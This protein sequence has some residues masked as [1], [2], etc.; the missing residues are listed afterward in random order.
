MKSLTEKQILQYAIKGLTADIDE[1]EKTVN[2]GK[3]YLLQYEKGEQPKTPKSPDEI[4]A[5]IAEKQVE[6]EK[7]SEI[8][9]DLK[10]KIEVTEG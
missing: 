5:I 8:K 7:L 3:Q 2:K 1:L 10:W 6:I 4:K 9:F